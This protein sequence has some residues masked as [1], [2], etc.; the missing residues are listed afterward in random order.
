MLGPEE[1]DMQRKNLT[2][3]QVKELKI[4]YLFNLGKRHGTNCF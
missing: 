3:F 2:E 1:F 4:V